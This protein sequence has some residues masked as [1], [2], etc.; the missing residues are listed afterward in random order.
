[1]YVFVIQKNESTDLHTIFE[2][3]SRI[4]NIHRQVC[5]NIFFRN[6]LHNRASGSY[7]GEKIP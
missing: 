4:Y 2:Y 6:M 3:L 5:L 7:F 1:M